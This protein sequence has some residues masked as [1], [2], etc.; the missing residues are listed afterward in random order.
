VPKGNYGIMNIALFGASGNIGRQIAQEAR[1]RGH[2][3]TAIVRDPSQLDLAHLRLKAVK[4]DILNPAEVALTAAGHD[5]VI[6]AYGPGL[7]GNP[8]LITEA[9]RAL[10]AGAQRAGVNRLIVVGGAG[11]LEAAP[12]V[13]LMNM[14]EY[15]ADWKPVALAHTDALAI[16][17]GNI[18]VDWTFMSPAQS[19]VPGER[20]GQYRTGTDQL[21]RDA[22]GQSHISVEDFAVALVDELENP[23]FIRRRFTV[24]Y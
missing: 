10:L 14:P 1:E 7:D 3:V 15:P 20:T 16:L 19:I 23:K 6:S 12:G 24:G 5:A 4:G 21:L 22:D 9:A 13:A 2:N 18:D 8:Q 11:S 17:Q